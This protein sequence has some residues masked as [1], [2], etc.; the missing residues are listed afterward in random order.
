MSD[1]NYEEPP[2]EII[3]TENRPDRILTEKMVYYL[4]GASPWLR[5]VSI[6]GFVFLG[7]SLLFTFVVIAGAET[8][9]DALGT[10]SGGLFILITTLP[11]L[12]LGFF[13]LLFTLQFGN[14]IK[15]YLH[16]KDSADLEEAFKN[17]KSLWVLSGVV[18]IICLAFFVLAIFAVIVIAASGFGDWF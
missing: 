17:N 15:M 7:L 6:V 12:L 1:L 16:T 11:F 18:C 2:K 8:F 14:K 9:D 13:C 4:Q 10:G 5:F 3:V